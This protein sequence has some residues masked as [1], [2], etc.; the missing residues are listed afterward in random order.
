MNFDVLTSGSAK[1]DSKFLNNQNLNKLFSELK[2][3]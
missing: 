2:H 3:K 1:L